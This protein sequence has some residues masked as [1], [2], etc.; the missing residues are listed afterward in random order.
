MS[1]A[2]VFLHQI[3]Q[4][5]VSLLVPHLQKENCMAQKETGRLEEPA[6]TERILM[7]QKV[8][9]TQIE[10]GSKFLFNH[11]LAVEFCFDT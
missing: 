10:N 2:L 11:L 4:E 7:Y 3:G 5:M 1:L 9:E 6:G 8:Q